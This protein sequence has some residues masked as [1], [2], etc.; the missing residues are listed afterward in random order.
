MSTNK[1]IEE[2][3][4]KALYD[5]QSKLVIEASAKVEKASSDDEILQIWSDLFKGF[6]RD[7]DQRRMKL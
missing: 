7:S 3:F 5:Q 1:L 6:K 2:A 4:L